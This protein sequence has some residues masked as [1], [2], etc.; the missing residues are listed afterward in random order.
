MLL[1]AGFVGRVG[2]STLRSN[3]ATE[4]NFATSTSLSSLFTFTRA[5]N[6]TCFNSSGVLTTASTDTPRFD[7]DPSTLQLRGLLLEGARTNLCLQSEGFNGAVWIKVDSTITTNTLTAPDGA[8]TAELITEGST[9]TA[10]VT[11]DVT[12][13]SGATF[14]VSV[15]LKRGNN[16]WMRIQA[17]DGTSA[18]G[19]ITYVN[20]ATGALG[21]T[22]N[23]GTGT[24]STATIQ[25]LPSG[26]YR[27]TLVTTVAASTTARIR[28]VSAASDGGGRVN[29]ATY[30]AWGAGIEQATFASSYIPTTTA[31][32]TRAADVCTIGATAFAQVMPGASTR[33]TMVVAYRPIGL[34]P[35]A[36]IINVNTDGTN[37][38][39]AR[40]ATGA[41]GT[42]VWDM[43][44]GAAQQLAPP[45]QAAAL[46]A[47]TTSKIAFAWELNNVAVT[48]NNA[49]VQTDASCTPPPV[50]QLFLGRDAGSANN[51]FGHFQGLSLFPQRQPDA[52]VQALTA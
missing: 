7:Y 23:V 19:A 31:A 5:S 2:R 28:L 42:V 11:Q 34:Q 3:R 8:T 26:W 39:S 41:P 1:P 4:F 48:A 43:F 38:S 14:T 17:V 35:T 27:V 22:S 13:S 24:G 44:T 9:G 37:Y 50:T 20:L 49:S 36:T 25:A 10:E 12:I 40:H 46:T 45:S 21:T 52:T 18:N 47:G 30:H 33:G 32:A 15:F 6:A 29:N 51:A 16:D